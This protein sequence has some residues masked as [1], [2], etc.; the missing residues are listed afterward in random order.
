MPII[1]AVVDTPPA[2]PWWAW[3]GFFAFITV[4]LMID[5]GVFQRESHEVKMKEALAWCLIWFTLALSFNGLIW[6]WRGARLAQEFLASYLVELCLSIDNVFV[7]ILVFAYFKVAPRYQ[8]R[9]LFWGIIGAVIMRAVF[10]L[11][12]VSVIARLVGC[13]DRDVALALKGSDVAV[14]RSA[15]P[16][17]RDGDFYWADLVGLKVVNIQ[18]EL[19]GEVTGLLAT[20]ANDV[21]RVVSAETERLVPYVAH[22]IRDVDLVGREIRV[23]WGLDW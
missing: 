14:A 13:D 7:F 8:H 17:P 9:V 23:E 18:G 2:L 3:A 22:V 16:P 4:M 12:G 21:L 5:L 1:L 6:W 15:L 11:V 10:I 19:I 20:G